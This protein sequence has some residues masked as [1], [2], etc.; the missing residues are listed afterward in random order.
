MIS[1][2]QLLDLNWI[3]P[4]ETK[5]NNREENLTFLKNALMDFNDGLS[6]KS[7]H[8]TANSTRSAIICCCSEQ[9]E[10]PLS[11]KCSEVPQFCFSHASQFINSWKNVHENFRD[12]M[13][14]F[15]EEPTTNKKR[16]TDPRD[17]SIESLTF[18]NLVEAVTKPKVIELIRNEIEKDLLGH[19]ANP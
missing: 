13:L 9:K 15:V 8:T 12:A 10:M 5:M 18:K 4:T 17:Q 14:T 2:N 11:V 3:N 16:R 19:N 1:T 7:L 6:D